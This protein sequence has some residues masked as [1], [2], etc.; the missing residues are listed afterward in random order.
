MPATLELLAAQIAPVALHLWLNDASA[1]REVDELLVGAPLSVSVTVSSRNV[2]GFG[3]FYLARDL[4]RD[5]HQQVVFIDDDQKFGSDTIE[6]LLAD[7]RPET[8]CGWWAFRFQ[9]VDRVRVEP[10]EDAEYIGT[11]GMITDT[12]LFADPLMFACPR[13]YWFVEDFWLS[14]VAAR[15]GWQL[16]RGSAEFDLLND[17]HDLFLTL[18]NTKEKMLRHLVRHGWEVG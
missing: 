4:A 3:R 9:G 2:G 17:S 1:R 14:Y 7:H 5:G 12:R 16:F 18:G 13:R 8:V 11:G 10:G 6:R 15:K